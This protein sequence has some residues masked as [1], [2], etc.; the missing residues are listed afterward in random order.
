MNF[1]SILSLQQ[2]KKQVSLFLRNNPNIPDYL[3]RFMRFQPL[4]RSVSMFDINYLIIDIET[5]GLNAGNDAI[6]SI[7][8]V[9]LNS[10][11]LELATA[12]HHF[13]KIA[14]DVSF[15]NA[16]IHHILPDMLK[17]GSELHDVLKEMFMVAKGRRIVVHGACIEAEFF[18]A[19][20]RRK[21]QLLS[22]PIF[23][24]DTLMLEKYFL[25][26]RNERDGD[27]RL[28]V[29]RKRYGLPDSPAH[30]AL[31]D[32]VAT[33][34]LFLCQLERLKGFSKWSLG[35]LS[36]VAEVVAK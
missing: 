35:C 22:V 15:E 30:D 3:S 18:S 20:F 31:T 27:Y 34:E 29:T 12:R 7:G 13:I 14:D 5:S 21:Y 16:S 17:N 10:G 26:K 6:L 25:A 1:P 23:Y 32:A 4:E 19:F 11:R 28:M 9:C 36:R 8:W 2:H 33:A 24:I